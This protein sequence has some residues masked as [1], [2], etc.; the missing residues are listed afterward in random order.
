MYG[1]VDAELLWIRL[2]GKYLVNECN[3]KRS[4][5]DSCIFFRKYEKGKLELVISVH[6]YDVFMAGKPETLKLIKEKIK[7]KFNI[8]E[9]GNVN[10]FLG[11]Y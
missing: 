2:L 10:K 9:S 8:S 7:E 11:F 1:N 5:A 4:K 3:L 6:V